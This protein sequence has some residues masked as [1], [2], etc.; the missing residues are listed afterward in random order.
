[1]SEIAP[2]WFDETFAEAPL[3]A[4]LRGM[5]VERSVALARTAWDL[6]IDSVELPLQTAEDEAA[7]RE[8]ARLGAE[9]GKVVGAGTIVSVEQIA[10]ANGLG[11]RYL[12]SPGLDPVIVRAAQDAGIPVLPGVATPSEV[13]I[14]RSLGLTWLKAFPAQWLGVDWFRHM[15]GPFPQVRFVAT[16][17]MDAGNAAQF[18]AAGVRVVAVGAALEDPDQLEQLGELLDSRPRP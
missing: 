12:V 15:R 9:R 10:L 16:G 14:A 13:Q 18:L 4:I 2:T 6:G 8:V 3:M 11:A 5:G 1:M 17:G 7:L